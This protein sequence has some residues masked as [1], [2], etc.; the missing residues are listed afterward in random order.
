MTAA[1][2]VN[3]LPR[4]AVQRSEEDEEARRAARPAGVPNPTRRKGSRRN[5]NAAPKKQRSVWPF[6]AVKSPSC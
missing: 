2:A 5:G 1:S 6:V 4:K 3:L